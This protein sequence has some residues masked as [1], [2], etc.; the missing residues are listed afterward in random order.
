MERKQQV[1]VLVP[2]Y[3]GGALVWNEKIDLAQME[4]VFADKEL[5]FL[6]P[7]GL[8]VSWLGDV[9]ARHRSW[10]VERVSTAWMRSLPAYNQMMLS[11][12]F[13]KQ[14]QRYD[15]VLI[16]QLDAFPISDRLNEFCQMAY[17]VYGAPWIY[18]WSTHEIAGHRVR[19]RVGN[20]GFSLR[21]I[22]ACIDVLERHADVAKEWVLSED[23]FFAYAGKYLDERLR[24]APLRIA[25]QFAVESDALRHVKKCGG[26]LPFGCHGW[27]RYSSA[28]YQQV[29]AMM[30]YDVSDHVAEMQNLDFVDQARM[31]QRWKNRRFHN[32]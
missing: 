9:L 3:H 22:G 26:Q 29:L 32:Q 20:G 7:R 31:I 4:K 13:Y 18:P 8:R 6:L 10:R 17:D 16:T 25:R 23:I 24:V 21:R 27:T 2:V 11:P 30:G 28:F 1:L 12:A 14:F 15:F 5:A 19:M